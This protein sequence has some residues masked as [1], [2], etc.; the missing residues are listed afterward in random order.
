M[1]VIRSGAGL[2]ICDVAFRLAAH[3][4]HRSQPHSARGRCAS[5]PQFRQA[6]ASAAFSS[7]HQEQDV[8]AAPDRQAPS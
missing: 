7:W 4:L 8:T 6:I 1:T 3:R 2:K 5:C